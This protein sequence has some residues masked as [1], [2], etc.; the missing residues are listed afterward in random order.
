MMM[1]FICE[2]SYEA[3]KLSSI[4]TLQKDNSL[5]VSGIAKVIENEVVVKLKD[6]SHHSILFKDQNNALMLEKMFNELTL[7]NN[8]IVSTY[9]EDN[10]IFIN[11]K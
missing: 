9:Y 7:D 3:E 2:D 4:F 5:Y 1:K 10:K 6:G 8:K 11:F